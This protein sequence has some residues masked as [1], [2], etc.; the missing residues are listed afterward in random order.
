MIQESNRVLGCFA[1]THV[2][3]GNARAVIASILPG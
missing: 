1:E 2:L 3:E